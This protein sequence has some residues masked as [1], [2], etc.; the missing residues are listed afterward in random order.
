MSDAKAAKQKMT[1]RM[2]KLKALHQARQEAR[3]D[4]HGEVKKEVERLNLPSNWKAREEKADWLTKDKANRD[5]AQEKGLDYERVKMLNVSAL[6]QE[7][8]E[9]LKKRGQKV[10]DDG[11]DSY[12]AQTA[13]QYQRM[14]RAM[15]SKDLQRYSEQKEALG[16]NYF[17]SNPVMEGRVKDTKES[18]DRMVKDLEGQIERRKNSSRRR[19]YNDNEDIDYINEKNRKLN[20]KL[21]KFYDPYTGEIREALERGTAI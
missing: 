11:F 6:E 16:E 3:N 12:E 18:V 4:N 5:A 20:K 19:M 14:V 21:A 7:R 17:T 1:E 13:R 10:G 9:K 15:P 8:M 2:A